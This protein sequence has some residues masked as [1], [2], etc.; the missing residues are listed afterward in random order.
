MR[1]ALGLLAL[2]AVTVAAD[3]EDDELT[4]VGSYSLNVFESRDTC[5]QQLNEVASQIRI[6]RAGGE[7]YRVEFGDAGTLTGEFDDQGLLQVTGPLTATVVVGGVPT[8][9]ASTMRMQV[10]LK[11]SGD[12]EASGRQTFDGTYPGVPGQCIIEFNSQGSRT[13]RAPALPTA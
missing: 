5:D 4:I 2:A 12:I 10:G 9:V 8:E 7:E 3:C 11:R 1:K 13:S 6:A